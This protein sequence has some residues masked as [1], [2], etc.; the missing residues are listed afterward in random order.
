MSC[1]SLLP[2]FPSFKPLERRDRAVIE[3]MTAH[4]PPYSD[5]N[6]A[7]LWCWNT[8]GSCELS[9]LG[10][11]LVVAMKDYLTDEVFLSF[12]GTD[13]AAQTALALIEYAA[14]RRMRPVLRLV[15]QDVVDA[16]G[17]RN[18]LSVVEDHGSFDY[19]LSIDDWVDLRGGKFRN[20]RN[21][22]HQAERVH[23]PDFLPADL[24]S[25][26]FREDAV[27]LFLHWSHR[28]GRFGLDGTANELMAIR[29]AFQL[30]DEPGI[31][32]FG[33]FVDGAMRGFSI[34]E[35]LHDGYA[36]GHFWKAD[37]DL[38]GLYD[39]MLHRTC[40]YLQEKGCRFLNVEQDL[41]RAGL[42][43]S[44]HLLRPHHFLKKFTVAEISRG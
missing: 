10:D 13:S 11:N 16:G 6:F 29:R 14:R 12:I 17:L 25:A 4:L 20:K 34:N 22:I 32:C 35:V 40:C 30:H 19:V 39:V 37:P 7:S 9:R 41:G 1:P 36:M 8:D 26:Q 28:R 27:S 5:F 33:M 42:A 3:R 2:C 38:P 44:K 18:R 24:E 15:P 43:T 23:G 31:V 21:R